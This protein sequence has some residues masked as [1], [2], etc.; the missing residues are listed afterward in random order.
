[1]YREKI[2]AYIDSKKDEMIED[3]KTLVRINS[4]RG[5]S[6]EGKPFG[7]GPA[8]VIAAAEGL[9]KQYGLQTTNYDNYV[10]TGDF[11]TQE[12]ALDI[13]AHLDVV[14]VT[15]DWTVTEPFQPKVVDGRIYGRGTAD[16]NG[17]WRSRHFMRC[18]RSGS[19]GF[20]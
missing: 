3:L 8:K 2:D 6:E 20:R 15:E 5:R 13:L 10:V 18:V 11:G 9:M 19:W 1:M 17:T 12:K 4:Q 7:D 14:P 16:D